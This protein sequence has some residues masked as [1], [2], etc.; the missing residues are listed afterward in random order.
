MES[1]DSI[2]TEYNNTMARLGEAYLRQE[3][4]THEII[5]LK[6]QRDALQ[7]RYQKLIAPPAPT[8]VKEDTNE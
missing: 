2:Q 6:K 5:G 7:L 8:P 4:A 1:L 3:A